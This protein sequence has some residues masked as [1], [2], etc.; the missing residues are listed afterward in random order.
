MI[1]SYLEYR[2]WIKFHVTK[3]EQYKLPQL[4][5]VGMSRE[6]GMW[7]LKMT[8]LGDWMGKG[9]KLKNVIKGILSRLLGIFM[10]KRE[11]RSNSCRKA[12]KSSFRHVKFEVLEGYANGTF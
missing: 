9:A 3:S 2:E 4:L 11:V 10:R 6:L 8:G 12:D 5:V 1:K 7:R